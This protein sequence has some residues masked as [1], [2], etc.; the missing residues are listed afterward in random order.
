MI[1]EIRKIGQGGREFDLSLPGN[2]LED[3]ARKAGDPLTL[4]SGRIVGLIE[5][6]E[7][8]PVIVATVEAEIQ[9]SC[10][11]CLESV[12]LTIREPLEL[13]LVSPQQAASSGE[14][15]MDAD[16]SATFEVPEGRLDLLDVAREAIFLQWTTRPLCTEECKGLCP[17]CGINRNG[18][19]C[20]CVEG[21]LDLRLEPLR[22]LLVR[23]PRQKQDEEED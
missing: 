7:R 21:P 1:I 12:I 22:E 23:K 16:L 3:L 11:R 8:Q 10:V 5:L 4:T 15:E 17:T 2:L 13:A 14:A 19:E 9:R 18:L 6:Q 20:A